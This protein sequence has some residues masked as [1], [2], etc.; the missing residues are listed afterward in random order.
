[1]KSQVY[2]GFIIFSGISN[3]LPQVNIVYLN[4]LKIRFPTASKKFSP[5][6]LLFIIHQDSERSIV[7]FNLDPGGR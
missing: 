3:F 7:L 1:M 4:L 6:G 5:S 2:S